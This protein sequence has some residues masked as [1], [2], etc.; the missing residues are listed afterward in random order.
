MVYV[1][2]ADGFEEIEALT[3]VDILR[4]AGTK[5]ETVAI[6]TDG[7][8]V[9]GA[10]GITV[11]A[12]K[13]QDTVDTN[14]EMLVLPG[15]QPG[16]QNLENSRVVQGMLDSAWRKGI[17]IGAICAAPSI[18]GHKNLLSGKTA[19]CYPEYEK[20]LYGASVKG[21]AVCVDG[22]LITG[23][24]PGAAMNF[25]LALLE[26]LEGPEAMEAVRDKLS[27]TDQVLYRN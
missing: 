21:S 6:G 1:L 10:H 20:D 14:F 13:T 8:P 11:T 22:N 19:V 23:N 17:K 3:A 25:A 7:R 16:T 15:G 24:G 18:L 5:V 2:L 27:L 9:R 12:D 26:Q 4:R